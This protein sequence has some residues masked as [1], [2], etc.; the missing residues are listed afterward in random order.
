MISNTFKIP[1]NSEPDTYINLIFDIFSFNGGKIPHLENILLWFPDYLMKYHQIY[2]TMMLGDGPLSIPW[3]FYIAIM[4]ISCY[5]CDY[6]LNRLMT[7]YIKTGGDIK[8][9][10]CGLKACPKKLQRLYE[11]N[12]LLAFSPWKLRN[13]QFFDVNIFFFFN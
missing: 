12:N 4:A 6:F 11:I 1:L 3:R 9:L 10:E 7:H 13:S 5:G 8:W 2:Q